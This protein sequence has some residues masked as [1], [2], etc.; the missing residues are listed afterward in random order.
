MAGRVDGG[1]LVM[2]IAYSFAKLDKALK[3]HIIF[4]VI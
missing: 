1:L 2:V 3:I 4:H